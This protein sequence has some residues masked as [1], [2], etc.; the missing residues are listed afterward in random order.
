HTVQDSTGVINI[1]LDSSLDTNQKTTATDSVLVRFF[2][3][4]K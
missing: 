4:V 1:D 2:N 3:Y